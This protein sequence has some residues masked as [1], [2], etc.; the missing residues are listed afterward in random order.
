MNSQ[1]APA[2]NP[3]QGDI[4]HEP[5]QHVQDHRFRLARVATSVLMLGGGLFAG[6]NDAAF[7]APAQVPDG[8]AEVQQ[9]ISDEAFTSLDIKA[10]YIKS[11]A[12]LDTKAEPIVKHP[13]TKKEQKRIESIEE[14]INAKERYKDIWF[15]SLDEA[16]TFYKGILTSSEI[17]FYYDKWPLGYDR[18]AIELNNRETTL[19]ANN[20]S[21]LGVVKT[22][23]GIGYNIYEARTDEDNDPPKI[24]P[25]ALDVATSLLIN[26]LSSLDQ[27]VLPQAEIERL[28]TLARAGKLDDVAVN[29]IIA[30]DINTCIIPNNNAK[31][32]RQLQPGEACEAGGMGIDSSDQQNSNTTSYRNLLI[33]IGRSLGGGNVVSD[34]NITTFHEVV[35]ALMATSTLTYAQRIAGSPDND[36]WQREHD[37]VVY[38]LI[39]RLVQ[40][41]DDQGGIKKELEIITGEHPIDEQSSQEADFSKVEIRTPQEI[42]DDIEHNKGRDLNF[43]CVTI[44]EQLKS[45]GKDLSVT[46]TIDYPVV[47]GYDGGGWDALVN[48][49]TN[50]K[51]FSAM[52]GPDGK[53]TVE[54]VKFDPETMVVMPVHVDGKG[55]EITTL[56]GELNS[57]VAFG[58]YHMTNPDVNLGDG[59]TPVATEH[60]NLPNLA[61][62]G[63]GE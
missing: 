51:F 31:T 63:G 34:E 61:K 49:G 55:A 36:V 7:E 48:P 37:E 44:V 40:I 4:L 8:E 23:S 26:E 20:A 32:L 46:R 22:S 29:I 53:P 38:P 42:A 58:E 27:S 33:L 12:F 60:I 24:D 56:S 17:K 62:R 30:D 35:H 47:E 52:P 18:S 16:K 59:V 14:K 3:E 15:E 11:E 45:G 13:L 41:A 10:A 25:R 19:E 21:L 6:H 57:N 1:P 54:Q 9:D 2:S 43:A 28:Q 39:A 50:V 5:I